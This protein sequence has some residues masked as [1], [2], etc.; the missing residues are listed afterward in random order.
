MVTKSIQKVV[1][2]YAKLKLSFKVYSA[3]K[4]YTGY[5]TKIYP[6]SLRGQ[7]TEMEMKPAQFKILDKTLAINISLACK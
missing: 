2:R 3:W 5:R 1:L 7:A 4:S 6:L